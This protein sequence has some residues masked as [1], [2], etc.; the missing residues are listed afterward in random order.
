VEADAAVLGH[1]QRLR[2]GPL[3]ARRNLLR[4]LLGD[5]LQLPDPVW[6]R[7]NLAWVVFFAFMGALNLWVAYTFA[8]DTW[9]NFKL[10]GGIG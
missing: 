8:T 6:K 2:T 1:G 9:V 3:L 10:F 7:L 4:I 5:Q